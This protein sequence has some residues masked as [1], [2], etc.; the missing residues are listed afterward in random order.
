MKIAVAGKGGSGKT[1][2]AGTLARLLAREGQKGVLAID[3]DSNPNLAL[4][5]GLERERLDNLT[6]IPREVIERD[7]ATN[8]WVL[9]RA[10]DEIVREHGIVLVSGAGPV[11]RLGDAVA[12]EPVRGSWW[13]HPRAKAIFD[14]L[15]IACASPEV[16]VCKLVGAKQTLVHRRL[17]PALVRCAGGIAAGRLDAVRQE[18]TAS[19]AHRNVVTPF[20]EWV[21]A[22][23]AR[24]ARS[25]D[26]A[27]ARAL[28]GNAL[29]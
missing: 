1:T 11:P 15:Q 19:G 29:A 27:S 25:L 16:L 24:E 8:R 3:A 10:V 20:P 17:W 9:T 28:L 21:P 26:E 13:A 18:H 6:R 14:A 23:V 7:A 2:I 12:G 4:T 22:D 5:L